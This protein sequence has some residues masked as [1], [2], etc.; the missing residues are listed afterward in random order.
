MTA[1]LGQDKLDQITNSVP[2]A[3]MASPDEIAGV[4]VFLAGPDAAYITGAVLPVD[5]GLGMGH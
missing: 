3:R 1:S 2:L 4:V 5:G